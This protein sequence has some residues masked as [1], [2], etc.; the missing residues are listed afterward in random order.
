MRNN[1]NLYKDDEVITQLEQQLSKP[2]KD[3]EATTKAT[4][5]DLFAATLAGKSAAE[6]KGSECG[7]VEED[8]P[9]VKLNELLENLKLEDK[10]PDSIW[11]DEDE[12]KKGD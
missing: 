2:S 9:I 7:S 5:A 6:G 4:D 11:K 1:V 8:F 10:V 3:E 12:E